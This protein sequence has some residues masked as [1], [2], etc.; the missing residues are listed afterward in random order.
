LARQGH[1]DG[2]LGH[3]LKLCKGLCGGGRRP[4]LQQGVQVEGEFVPREKVVCCLGQ[5]DRQWRQGA[6]QL[7]PEFKLDEKSGFV[8]QLGYVGLEVEIDVQLAIVLFGRH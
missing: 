3:R 8:Q 2:T 1:D 5:G 7:G 6:I 4:V